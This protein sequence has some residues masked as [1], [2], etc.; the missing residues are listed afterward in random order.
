MSKNE[1]KKLNQLQKALKAKQIATKKRVSKLRQIQTNNTHLIFG[2]TNVK[3]E[4]SG[5]KRERRRKI[6]I[7]A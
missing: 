2:M 3:L 1:I 6:L 7:E 4:V 5:E